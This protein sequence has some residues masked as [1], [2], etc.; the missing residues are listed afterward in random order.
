MLE[1]ANLIAFLATANPVECRK[2]YHET[3]GLLFMGED[4]NTLIFDSNGTILRVQKGR[5]APPSPQTALGWEVQDIVNHVRRLA[6]SGVAA[7]RYNG[8]EQDRD[9]IWTG[10]DGTMVAWIRDP[11]GNVL[12]LSE[13]PAEM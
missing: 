8:L 5:T 9:G 13:R 1:N 11:D 12:Y 7:V 10:R 6:A 3:L 4:A 2:F